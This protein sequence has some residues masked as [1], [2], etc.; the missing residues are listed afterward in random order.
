MRSSARAAT[1]APAGEA[2]HVRAVQPPRS[3]VAGAP[4]DRQNAC[5]CVDGYVHSKPK[6]ERIL[7]N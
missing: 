7:S 1:T 2:D 5:R 4:V 3:S 6:L